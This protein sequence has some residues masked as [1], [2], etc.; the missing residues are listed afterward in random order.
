MRAKWKH[1]QRSI[2]SFNLLSSEVTQH[3][4]HLFSISIFNC[5]FPYLP[6]FAQHHNVI[7]YVQMLLSTLTLMPRFSCYGFTPA[8]TFLIS[9][10]FKKPN[11]VFPCRIT[12]FLFCLTHSCFCSLFLFVISAFKPTLSHCTMLYTENIRARQKESVL[13]SFYA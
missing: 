13:L 2:Y 6:L 9:A 12:T 4:D 3:R 11:T 1:F 8:V 5:I 7:K 10:A